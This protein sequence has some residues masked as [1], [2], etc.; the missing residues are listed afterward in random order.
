MRL[1]GGTLAL[2][3]GSTIINNSLRERMT[4]LGIPNA[5]ITEIINDPTIIPKLT[6]NTTLTSDPQFQITPSIAADILSALTSG[7]HNVFYLNASLATLCVVVSV[8][9]IRHKELVRPGE[10]ELKKKA[11]EAYR[12]E[13]SEGNDNVDIEPGSPQPVEF[14]DMSRL[15]VIDRPPSEGIN[16]AGSST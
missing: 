14:V 15:S 9:M 11:E 5:L 13:R 4:S 10:K 8:L 7:F 12:K 6:G 3:I 16:R 2:A 1:L